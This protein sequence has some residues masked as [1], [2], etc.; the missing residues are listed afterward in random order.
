MRVVF[1]KASISDLE[2]ISEYISRDSPGAA[3]RV[4]QRI[5]RS[6]RRLSRFPRSARLGSEPGTR[7]LVATGLPF[8]VVYRIVEESA[9]PFVE[10]IAVL[11]AA[12][13]R[14]GDEVPLRTARLDVP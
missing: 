10:V 6:V 3:R 2:G 8:I 12:R 14:A 1:S 13:D 11:H 7:E 5:R 4:V 9:R